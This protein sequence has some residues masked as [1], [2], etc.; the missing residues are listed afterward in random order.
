MEAQEEPAVKE[1]GTANGFVNGVNGA[2]VGMG[3]SPGGPLPNL[4]S[5]S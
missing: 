2:H 3:F 5:S 4:S 1:L